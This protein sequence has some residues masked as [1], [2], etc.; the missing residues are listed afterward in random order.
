[1]TNRQ[2]SLIQ[3]LESEITYIGDQKSQDNLKIGIT[4]MSQGL[5]IDPSSFFPS[6]Q[7]FVTD[8]SSPVFITDI[9]AI[10]REMTPRGK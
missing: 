9:W 1:M 2:G 10:S 3:I 8:I 4:I 7:L 6:T 5:E